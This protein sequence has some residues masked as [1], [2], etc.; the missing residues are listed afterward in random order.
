[1]Q[2]PLERFALPEFPGTYVLIYP[3]H[4]LWNV[5]GSGWLHDDL[6]P[7]ASASTVHVMSSHSPGEIRGYVLHNGKLH[8]RLPC[9]SGDW[10]EMDSAVL[11]AIA[12]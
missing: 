2:K 1:M 6:P 9:Y 8:K 7:E 11:A 12:A 5:Q 10:P 4:S 3:P